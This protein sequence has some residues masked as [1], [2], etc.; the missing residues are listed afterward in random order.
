MKKTK[1]MF[2]HP[3]FPINHRHKLVIP[4][5]VCKI[6]SY[7]RENNNSVEMKL[8]DAHVNNFRNKQI[9]ENIK[10][11]D[12]DIVAFGFWTCQSPFVYK[13]SK[14]IRE[15]NNYIKIIYGG[16]HT[17]FN[18]EE[19]LNYCDVAIIGE[20]EKT[21][22]NLVD[23][24]QEKNS[25][26]DVKGIAFKNSPTVVK[27]HDQPLI[28]DLD[29]IPYP[30]FDL[31]DM[32]K[33][34]NSDKLRQLHV[35]G[36]KRVPIL[37]SRGCPYNCSFC[38]S[39]SMWGR[40][41]RWKSPSKVI[42]EIKRLNSDF[43]FIRFQ[44]YDDNFLLNREFIERLCDLL[45]TLDFD[46]RWVALSRAAH[47]VE[48]KDLLPKLKQA[49]C[50]G[51]EMGLETADNNILEKINKEQN[52]DIVDMAVKFQIEA[53]LNPL[54]TIMV[55]NPGETIKSIRG[56]REYV[57]TKIP[58]SINYKFFGSAPNLTLGQ[59]ATPAPGTAFFK[60]RFSQGIV[61]M[62]DWSDYFHHQINFIPH[63]LLN[64]IPLAFKTLN[65]YDIEQCVEVAKSSLFKYFP[66]N[67]KVD[68]KN[69]EDMKRIS[70]RYYALAKGNKSI[71]EIAD[72]ISKE[73]KIDIEKVL[74]FVALATIVFSQKKIVV[75]K[76]WG[77]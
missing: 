76:L 72:Q 64:D 43:G 48:N 36:G 63:S 15:L 6:A 61:L 53:G 54:Y 45:I 31:V 57:E 28:T 10:E 16:I 59:F 14:L 22:T 13:L 24:I 32:K 7:L 2:V 26:Y 52:M 29:D 34:I 35:I 25:L 73:Y 50:V 30:A 62:D 38:L 71:K 41:V 77:A 67:E 12:P 68:N 58:E 40:K 44:F 8:V 9:L 20:A 39:P 55:L 11:F 70:K 74:R 33:Y 18:H 69:E 4:I 47:V 66:G 27:T 60:N 23:A 65:E 49:G 51:I 56:L 1:I 46:I 5:S 42:E 3:P 21:F 17:S 37:A 19:C 75:E